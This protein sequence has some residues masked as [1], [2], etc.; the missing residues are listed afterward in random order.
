MLYSQRPNSAKGTQANRESAA[1]WAQY[2]LDN[3]ATVDEGLTLLKPIQ[4]T[5]AEPSCD[6]PIPGNINAVDRFQ[7]AAYFK[8]MLPELK[9]IRRAL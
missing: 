8:A 7:R 6:L 1:R 2:V 9:T 5:P 3:A 4:V